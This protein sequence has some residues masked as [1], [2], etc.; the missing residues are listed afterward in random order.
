MIVNSEGR[1]IFRYQSNELLKRSRS[2]KHIVTALTDGVTPQ[3]CL[4]V[5]LTKGG[6]FRVVISVQLL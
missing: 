6:G 3:E 4:L 5:V 2:L 1:G